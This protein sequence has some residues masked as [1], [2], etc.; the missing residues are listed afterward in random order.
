MIRTILLAAALSVAAAAVAAPAKPA[1]SYRVDGSIAL[2]DG[3]WDYASFEPVSR[4]LFVAHGDAIAVVDVDHR[5]ARTLTTANGAH[6]VLPIPGT[7]LLAETDGKT[8]SLRLIDQYTGRQTAKIATGEKPDAAIWDAAAKRV[9]VI[10]AK[11]GTVS[12]VDPA[13]AKVIRSFTLKPGLE[14][15][16]IDRRGRLFVNNEDENEIE[17]VDLATGK[18]GAPIALTGCTEPSGLA[19]SARADRLIAACANEVAAVVTP[20]GNKLVTLIPIGARP[21]AVILDEAR[22]R[23]FIPSGGS[24]TLSVLTI[25]ADGSIV[26]GGRV[27]T[28]V[29][30]RT[31]ALDPK[32]GNLYLP[33]ARFGPVPAGGGRPVAQPGSVAVLVVRRS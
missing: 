4:R 8:G 22:G 5:R 27:T 18:V 13:A 16:A 10:N 2:S 23:A 31:G 3:G 33:T 17:T 12:V 9:L 15:A 21:D 11:S 6:A 28:Q 1:A 29:G 30:A 7:H 26:D 14:F 19:Y 32:T 24:G 25:A 20:V